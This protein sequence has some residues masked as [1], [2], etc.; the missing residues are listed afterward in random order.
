[1]GDYSGALAER[2]ALCQVDTTQCPSANIILDIDT[3]RDQ[4][5]MTIESTRVY[6]NGQ[7]I[8]MESAIAQPVVYSDMVQRVRVEKEGYL[9]SYAK[10]NDI[11]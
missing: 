11:E 6:L 2:D 5:G 1:M 4:S 9:D 7:P 3:A 8:I 10:F